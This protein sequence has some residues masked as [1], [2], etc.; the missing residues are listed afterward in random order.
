MYYLCDVT[1]VATMLHGSV[2]PY[3][4]VIVFINIG[5]TETR[6]VVLN[7]IKCNQYGM[8]RVITIPIVCVITRCNIQVMSPWLQ[9]CY[10]ALYVSTVALSY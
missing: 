3:P 9:L 8:T 1:V 2:C 4:T 6:L 5:D 7:I 10:T